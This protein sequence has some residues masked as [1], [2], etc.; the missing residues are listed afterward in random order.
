MSNADLLMLQAQSQSAKNQMA[1]QERMSNTAHQREVKDL[2]AAG[3]NPVLSA[4]GTGASTPNGAEG[5]LTGLDLSKAIGA[6]SSGARSS[7][8]TATKTVEEMSGAIKDVVDLAKNS[9]ESVSHRLFDSFS[10][11]RGSSADQRTPIVNNSLFEPVFSTSAVPAWNSYNEE[12]STRAERTGFSNDLFGSWYD[13]AYDRWT[14]SKGRL[15]FRLGKNG[16][17]INV[18][19]GEVMAALMRGTERTSVF[20]DN[21]GARAKYYTTLPSDYI[22]QTHRSSESTRDNNWRTIR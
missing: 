22:N 20:M 13:D 2:K 9:V 18:P 8:K 7:A 21:L 16:P 5:D 3:L 6:L 12:G 11:L 4:G 14:S 19:L 17:S 15:S 10:F 1:F